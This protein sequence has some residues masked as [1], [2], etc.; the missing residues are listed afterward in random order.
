M[1]AFGD[2]VKSESKDK[3]KMT[4]SSDYV[5][6]TEDH[7]TVI[8]VLD[9]QPK[10]C[11]THWIPPKHRAF[12]NANN[13][14]GIGII[15]S[16]RDTCPVCLWNKDQQDEDKLKARKVYSFNV[17]DRTPVATCTCGA[18]YYEIKGNYPTDCACGKPLAGVSPSPRNKVQIMQK[19]RKIVDQL[20]SF[21]EDADLGEV[22]GYDI[23]FDTRG[24]GGNSMTT[25][26]PK[27]KAKIDLKKTLGEDWQNKLF[28]INKVIEPLSP[29]LTE[30]VLKGESYYSVVK[31]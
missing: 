5:K 7:Q 25:C 23:K 26:I 30:R 4:F 2:T 31:A 10:S 9:K 18:E 13:G 6:L 19:G 21:E 22:T 12:P 11:W 29:E 16:G 14:K 24:K 8:R 20:A 27:Q 17:L 1:G 28:N 3:T 15:C